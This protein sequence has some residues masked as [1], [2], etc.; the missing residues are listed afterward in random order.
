MHKGCSK[1]QRDKRREKSSE[2]IALTSFSHPVP[3]G[4]L[5]TLFPTN[6]L[7]SC[8]VSRHS[9]SMIFTHDL[10]LNIVCVWGGRVSQE[11]IWTLRNTD[12]VKPEF[13]F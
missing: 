13:L 11:S 12:R 5:A 7:L 3:N 10:P 9:R 8:A 2:A 4:L 1:E 6:G